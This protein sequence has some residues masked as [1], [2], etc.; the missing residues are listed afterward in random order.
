M[1]QEG[2]HFLWK[3]V[4]IT[5]LFGDQIFR[6][7]GELSSALDS[8]HRNSFSMERVTEGLVAPLSIGMGSP[9]LKTFVLSTVFFRSQHASL[10]CQTLCNEE[11]SDFFLWRSKKNN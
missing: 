2:G 3:A 4:K 1:K 8:P 11:R 6:T 9:S 10:L 5:F 7:L